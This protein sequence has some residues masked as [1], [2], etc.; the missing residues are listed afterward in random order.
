[1]Q[2]WGQQGCPV[3]QRVLCFG[4]R[5]PWAG[6]RG[7]HYIQRG[8]GAVAGQGLGRWLI[9]VALW[10]CCC[11]RAWAWGRRRGSTSWRVAPRPPRSWR[12][13]R[14]SRCRCAG[15]Q[16]AGS[17]RAAGHAWI[18]HTHAC[19]QFSVS[20]ASPNAPPWTAHH[21]PM[22]CMQ[23]LA[24]PCPLRRPHMTTAGPDPPPDQQALPPPP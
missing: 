19:Q 20:A 18:I 13:P 4:C 21:P 7:R 14:T 5:C 22:V 17:W 8:C 9:L 3:L 24:P 23:A 16:L 6:E 2:A 1:V 11:S 15:G 12:C 10:L